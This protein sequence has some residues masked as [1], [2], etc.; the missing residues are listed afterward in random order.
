[1]AGQTGT[2]VPAEGLALE[3]APAGSDAVLVESLV[4]LLVALALLAQLDLATSLA[5]DRN[6]H[7]GRKHDHCDRTDTMANLHDCTSKLNSFAWIV[8]ESCRVPICP[9]G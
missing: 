5:G 9:L 8:T 6:R 7:D 1:M 3:Q 2:A 4:P